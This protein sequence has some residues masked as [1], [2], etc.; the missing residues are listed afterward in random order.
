MMRT[1]VAKV[2]DGL[3]TSSSSGTCSFCSQECKLVACRRNLIANIC[4]ALRASSTMRVPAAAHSEPHMRAI[5]QVNARGLNK[6]CDSYSELLRANIDNLK[7]KE[8][9][10]KAKMATSD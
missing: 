10:K 3:M 5:F 6:F 4:I 7:R 1:I 2:H 8:R 9:R